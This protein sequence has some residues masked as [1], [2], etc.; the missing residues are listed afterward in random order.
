MPES[1]CCA[2]E[3][4]PGLLSDLYTT[5]ALVLWPWK[6][7]PVFWYTA[8]VPGPFFINT[9]FL[10]GRALA[11][12]LVKSLSDIVATEAPRDEHARRLNDLIL[13]AWREDPTYQRVIAQL[14]QATEG[15]FPSTTYAAISGGERR[16]WLFSIPL[17][18]VLKRPHLFLFK[19]KS[20]FSATPLPSG[21]AVVHVA[22]LVNNGASYLDMWL[23]ALHALGL[24][25][26]GTVCVFCRNASGRAKLEAAGLKVLAL[27]EVGVDFFKR[28]LDAGLIDQDD[29]TQIIAYAE[30]PRRWAADYLMNRPEVFVLSPSDTKSPE[31]MRLFFER[32]PW[33]LREAYA[34]FF[35]RML[36]GLPPVQD[37]VC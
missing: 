23:P 28:S 37:A 36:D 7:G 13:G 24:T 19:D 10:I 18:E 14:A 29:Y 3:S 1:S 6:T 22:D 26:P 12:R 27:G 33:R 20:T 5:G 32:D 11:E 30:S 31:R 35:Q 16:D 25:C 9:E 4:S 17:A 21:Q 8:N 34:P 2:G 15:T